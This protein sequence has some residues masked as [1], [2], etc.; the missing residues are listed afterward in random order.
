M[1]FN[2]G[3]NQEIEFFKQKKQADTTENQD[4]ARPFFDKIC[5]FLRYFV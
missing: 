4:S 2:T 5:I 1:N 3:K